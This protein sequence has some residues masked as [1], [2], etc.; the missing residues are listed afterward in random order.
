MGLTPCLQGN[1]H[2]VCCSSSSVGLGFWH[3][4]TTGQ[5]LFL[6]VFV[7]F[8]CIFLCGLLLEGSSGWRRNNI[9]YILSHW[10]ANIFVVENIGAFCTTVTCMEMGSQSDCEW[11]HWAAAQLRLSAMLKCYYWCNCRVFSIALT[12]THSAIRI[13]LGLE[14]WLC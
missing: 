12:F 13:T 9:I 4:E 11:G 1:H 7:H 5:T 14:L 8:P 10:R 3:W 6:F 2:W